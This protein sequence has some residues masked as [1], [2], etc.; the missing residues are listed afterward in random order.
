MKK[1]KTNYLIVGVFTLSLFVFLMF[2]LFRLTGNNEDVETYYASYANIAGVKVGTIVSYGG[3]RIGQVDEIVPIRKKG[4]TH[5]K[6]TLSIIEGW[7]IPSGSK[8]KV[9]SPGMLSDKQIDI[10]EGVSSTFYKPGEEIIGKEEANFMSILNSVAAEVQEV[11]EESIKPFL[12]ILQKHV[13]SIGGSISEQLPKVI[14]SVQDVM[15]KMG[16]SMGALENMLS[17]DNAKNI[18]I[19]IKNIKS[20]T[21]RLKDMSS[22]FKQVREQITLLLNNS[23]SIVSDNKQDVRQAMQDMRKVMESLSGSIDSI[24]YNLES[25]GSNMNEFSRQIRENPGLLLGGSPQS[26][27]VN[28]NAR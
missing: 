10:E 22:D 6:L 4:K 27:K 18:N 5:F 8:A 26:D 3:Y 1:H 23:N 16:S 28:N 2:I 25:T 12:A 14:T 13:N 21:S 19:S 24:T 11:S 15:E 9:I 17:K 7:K 20:F